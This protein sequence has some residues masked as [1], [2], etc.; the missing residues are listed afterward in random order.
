MKA[1]ADLFSAETR[2]GGTEN[3]SKTQRKLTMTHE[4]AGHYRMKHSSET[5]LNPRIAEAVKRKAKNNRISCAS[6]HEI[7]DEAGATP[8]EVGIALDLLEMRITNCQLGLF[9][10]SPEKKVVRSSETV[11]PELEKAIRN[12]LEDNRIS[13]LSCWEIAERFGIARIEVSAACEALDFKI[14][15]CQLGAFR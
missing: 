7:A 9:G 6:A 5:E 14:R 13:C 12:S 15:A 8:A 10:H 11:S 1:M 3:N 4:D 2:A